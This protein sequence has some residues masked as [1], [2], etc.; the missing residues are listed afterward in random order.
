MENDV[1]CPYFSCIKGCLL[2][3]PTSGQMTFHPV[4]QNTYMGEKQVHSLFSEIRLAL[5]VLLRQ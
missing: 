1:N 2:E 5:T 4:L 3:Y